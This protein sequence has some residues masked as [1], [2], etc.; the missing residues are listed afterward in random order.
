[1]EK[2]DFLIPHDNCIHR[3]PKPG[4]VISYLDRE[5][6]I[7][8]NSNSFCGQRACFYPDISKDCKECEKRRKWYETYLKHLTEPD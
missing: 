1:M 6:G 3:H 8:R 5:A 2:A 7:P 4:S